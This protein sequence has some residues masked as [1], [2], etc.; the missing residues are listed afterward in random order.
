M[1][2]VKFGNILVEAGDGTRFRFQVTRETAGSVPPIGSEVSVMYEGDEAFRAI[3][4]ETLSR[5]YKVGFERLPS[6]Q[7]R[8]DGNALDR[9]LYDIVIISFI[10]MGIASACMYSLY[11]IQVTGGLSVG[12]YIYCILAG[13]QVIMGIAFFMMKSWAYA[14]ALVLNAITSAFL[15]WNMLLGMI[16]LVIVFYLFQERVRHYYE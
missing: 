7:T 5:S 14:G 1:G 9:G 16:P 12:I 13:L 3:L 4:I 2:G 10:Q 15:S 8:I 11:M 6:S